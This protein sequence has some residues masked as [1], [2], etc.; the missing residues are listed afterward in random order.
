MDGF[1]ICKLL[2]KK[3]GIKVSEDFEDYEDDL[4]E[5]TVEV[6]PQKKL[7][8]KTKINSSIGK[9]AQNW[10]INS[11]FGFVIFRL[12]LI[13]DSCGSLSGGFGGS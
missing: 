4:A 11:S 7:K 6:K 9:S 1:F 10:D 3:D 8:P 2:K 13:F 5:P 12:H